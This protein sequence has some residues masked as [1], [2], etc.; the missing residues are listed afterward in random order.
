MSVMDLLRRSGQAAAG[1][2]ENVA[3]R[4]GPRMADAAGNFG[5]LAR[6]AGGA[7]L[8][9]A[10]AYPGL[11]AGAG[12]FALGAG[13]G[14]E[15]DLVQAATARDGTPVLLV[16]GEPVFPGQMDEAEFM[17]M[18]ERASDTSGRERQNEGGG[19]LAAMGAAALGA[20][21]ARKGLGAVADVGRKANRAHKAAGVRYALDKK[22]GNK[23]SLK[24]ALKMVRDAYKNA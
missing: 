14:D 13:L 3:R 2:G 18:Y 8:D 15:G 9:T 22:H 6:G 23:P 11:T 19:L 5:Q 17:E 1:I 21:Y 10:Q 16:N 4:A 7:A 12:G 20:P 24:D